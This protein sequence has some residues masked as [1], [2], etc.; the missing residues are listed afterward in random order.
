M[1]GEEEEERAEGRGR[2]RK[3]KA[4]GEERM[5]YFTS[6]KRE[7]NKP[8]RWWQERKVKISLKLKGKQGNA[9]KCFLIR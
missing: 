6:V 5:T 8:R 7:G 1:E 3:W 9:E 4:G 2:D